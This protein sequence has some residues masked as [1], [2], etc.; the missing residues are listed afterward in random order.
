MPYHDVQYQLGG[1]ESSYEREPTDY[2][3][4]I[5]VFSNC[6]AK[7]IPHTSVSRDIFKYEY[8]P[9]SSVFYPTLMDIFYTAKSLS[10]GA[11]LKRYDPE[12][13][14]TFIK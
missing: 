13:I 11:F 8:E 3:I 6:V 10:Y 9:G 7:N 4:A 5:S 14:A 2:E 1:A 12:K